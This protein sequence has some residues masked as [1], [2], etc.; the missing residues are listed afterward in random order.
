MHVSSRKGVRRCMLSQTAYPHHARTHTHTHTHPSIHTH[1]HGAVY[2]TKCAHIPLAV[3]NHSLV[4]NNFVLFLPP[5]TPEILAMDHMG[6]AW[7]CVCVMICVHA[8]LSLSL[9]LCQCLSVWVVKGSLSL[10]VC[11][12]VCLSVWVVNITIRAY[13]RM[14]TIL[15]TVGILL[16]CTLLDSLSA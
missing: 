10:C 16:H 7:R 9:S 1:T 12:S 13:D 4:A 15:R 3:F 14:P 8:S 5:F 6:F 11:V 2:T